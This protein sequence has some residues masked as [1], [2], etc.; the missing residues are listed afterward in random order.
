MTTAVFELLHDA[1]RDRYGGSVTRMADAFGVPVQ[2]V[3]RWVH[4][5]DHKRTTPRP[6]ACE[7]I[8]IALDLDPDYVLELAGH[9]KPRADRPAVDPVNFE[10]NARLAR[11]GETLGRYPRAFWLAVVEASERMAGAGEAL[12]TEPPVSAPPEGGV[13]ASRQSP[14]R[15]NGGSHRPLANT[16]HL[17]E[18]ALA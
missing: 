6:L 1:M 14:K 15:G 3:S 5:D 9:R 18:P 13:S 11:L 8:A 2:S 12:G 7:K 10:L 17:P 16:S 4:E